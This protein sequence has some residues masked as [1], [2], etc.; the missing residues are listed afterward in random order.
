M[1]FD[2]RQLERLLHQGESDRVERKES[3]AGKS[4][5]AIR[6]AI[7][8][9]ANDLPGHNAPGV[10][11][12]GVNDAG[13]PSGVAIT[14]D[15]L[16][17]LADMKT[18]GNIL[19]PPSLAVEKRSIAEGEFA[20]ITVLPSD[21]PP[22]RYKG[23]IQVRTG[24]RKG[25]ATAQD[26]RILNEKRRHGD[27]PFDI[28][29]VPSSAL[30]D[31]QMRVFEGEYLPQA[32][33]PEVL[34]EN[35]RTL[36]ERLAATKMIASADDPSATVLGLLVLGK[37][38]RDFLP[39][40]YLQFLRIDGVDLA[41]PVLDSEEIDGTISDSL[42]RLD[43]KLRSHNRVSVNFLDGDQ[44]KRADQYPLAALQ[45]FARNAVMHRTYEATN[46]PT[47]LYWFRDRVE[48]MS[49]GG[50]FGIVTAANF[51]QPGVTDYRNPNLAEAMRVLGYVQRYGAGIAAARRLL[52]RAGHPDPRFEVTESSVLVVVEG[53]AS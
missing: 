29:P 1:R 9:F 39:G 25:I 48:I 51:G 46:S 37:R 27:R 17:T 41:D 7:C 21:S 53:I 44:E 23:T 14:D 20:V 3:I 4:P 38:P 12:I 47:R 15:L 16:R 6:E 2:D 30:N 10:I 36:Q 33:A 26:E 45:Q 42:R 52:A 49:P 5:T 35:D 50:P 19:P 28:Q 24:S 34:E 13:V 8:A 32:V 31:L 18:D 22:V 11:F 40:A 43:D